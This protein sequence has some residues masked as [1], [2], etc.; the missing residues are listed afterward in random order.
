[1]YEDARV[2]GWCLEIV[3]DLSVMRSSL[4]LSSICVRMSLPG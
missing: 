1:M 2:W 3:D 4:M